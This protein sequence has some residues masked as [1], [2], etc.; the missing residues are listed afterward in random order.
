MTQRRHKGGVAPGVLYPPRNFSIL[1]PALMLAL[2]HLRKSRSK[3]IL[4]T[5]AAP[6][7]TLQ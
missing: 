3:W 5:V 6:R 1:L 2:P 4:L 7:R